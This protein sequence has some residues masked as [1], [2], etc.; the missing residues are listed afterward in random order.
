[1]E[2]ETRE[3]VCILCPIAC[4]VN[5]EIVNGEVAK[6]ENAQC[7]R[8][9]DF[10][11]Q[12]V[13]SP[14]R[15][16]FTTI[17]VRGGKIPVLSVRSTGPVAKNMLMAIASELANVTVVAPVKLGDVVVKNILNLGIDIVATKD[18]EGF[19]KASG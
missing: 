5:V 18:V 16:F 10:S 1:M 14:E 8:G 2:T 15:D 19:S 13:R 3:I 12:E 11:V 17:R 7:K 9:K 4:E 6:I